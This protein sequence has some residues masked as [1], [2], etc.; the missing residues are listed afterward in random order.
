MPRDVREIAAD[1]ELSADAY[2][3]S[4]YAAGVE[5]RCFT[6]L[7]RE[8]SAAIGQDLTFSFDTA[9]V[10]HMK[11]AGFGSI[12]AQQPQGEPGSLRGAVQHALRRAGITT[13]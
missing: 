3:A 7:V 1:L 11:K 2:Q 13:E 6:A 12:L 5:S 4:I 8:L 9:I 10:M